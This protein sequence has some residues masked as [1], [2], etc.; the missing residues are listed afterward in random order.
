MP[1]RVILKAGQMRKLNMEEN[2]KAGAVTKG[3][4]L[5]EEEKKEN[6]N[7]LDWLQLRILSC[8]SEALML[9]E[10]RMP[11]PRMAIVYPTYL[12]NHRCIGCDYTEENKLKKVMTKEEFFSVVDQLQEIGVRGIEFCGGGEPTLNPHLP[13]VIDRIVAHNIHFGLLT[14]GTYLTQSL[15]KRLVEKGSYCRISIESAQSETFNYYKKPINKNA[16]LER[17]VE[18]I[19]SLVNLRNHAVPDTKLQISIKYSIDQNNLTDVKKAAELADELMVDS[20]QFKLIRNM[21]SEIKDESIVERLTE[22]LEEVKYNNKLRIVHDL[23][24]SKLINACWLSPLQV[25][26]DPLG[27][28]YI[29]C[30]YRHRKQT[31]RLGNLFQNDLK[32]I[33]YSQKHWE[34]IRGIDIDDC[35][36]Y[37]CRFHNYNNLMKN[38]IIE[39]VGQLHFI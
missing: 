17:I 35:N 38:L 8:Y 28:V 18:N 25:T 2:M 14:N 15:Q 3:V 24:K 4:G 12:C 39:D 1:S 10:G 29:C 7:V 16:G 26:I 37:D 30:Y 20:V 34:K 33:W 19:N 5:I 32:D 9:K 11:P 6:A 21:P 13:E 23:S 36:K 22:K 31:H 27:D